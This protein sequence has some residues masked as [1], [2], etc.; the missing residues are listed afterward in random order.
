MEKKKRKKRA[1]MYKMTRGLEK[2]RERKN[3][4][5]SKLIKRKREEQ[6][7]IHDMITGGIDKRECVGRGEGPTKFTTRMG[8]NSG[9]KA[10]NRVSHLHG[11]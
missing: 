9:N 3:E 7:G 4:R 5:P 11:A 6:R 10:G 8:Q 1:H 2:K